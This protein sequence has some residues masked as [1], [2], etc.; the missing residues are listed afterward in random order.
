MIKRIIEI[1]IAVHNIKKMGRV[2]VDLLGA[3][4]GALIEVREFD[5]L[6]QMYRI[7]NVE[8]ELMEPLHQD[9]LIAKFLEN[10]GDGF[11]H[12]AFEVD[13]ITES[14][15]WMKKHNV[16][17]INEIPVLIDRLKAIFLDPHSFKGVLIEIIEGDPA[18]VENLVLPTELQ[19]QKGNQQF[20]AEGILEVGIF[21]EDLEDAARFYSEIFSSEILTMDVEP[22]AVRKKIIRVGNVGLKLIEMGTEERSRWKFSGKKPVGIHFITL[23]VRPCSKVT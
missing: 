2:L 16:R 7:G 19:N 14:V 23:K 3:K 22:A 18:W 9:S 15:D 5:M 6:M 8:F 20:G 1:G 12:I 13:N 10:K 4:E 21:V 11:H 17:V